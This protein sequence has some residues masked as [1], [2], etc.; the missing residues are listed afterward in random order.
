[1]NRSRYSL[2]RFSL[3]RF[4]LTRPT[5]AL[6]LALCAAPGLLRADAVTDA[7]E[8]ALENYRKG[9]LSMTGAR[10]TEASKAL[11]ALQAGKLSQYL[12]EA[13]AGWTREVNEEAGNGMAMMGM[14]GSM[15]EA[16]YAGPDG[17]EVTLTLAAD[18]P[19]VM[20]MGAMLGNPQMMA[21]MGE[22]VEVGPQKMVNRDGEL[23]G[24]V[25][26]R[27][28]V[29]ASGASKEAMLAVISGLDFAGLATF[30]Q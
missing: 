9:D 10:L 11:A 13:P 1:M 23:A 22:L 3:T 25:A 6:A 14:G 20:S 18:N 17:A 7:L 19:M 5:L 2:T 21:M 4:S 30:D 26:G 29:Q 8:S 12:P 16:R 28:L 27:V 24:L 15:A